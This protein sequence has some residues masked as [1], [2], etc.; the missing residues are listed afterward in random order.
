[1]RKKL[2]APDIDLRQIIMSILRKKHTL[3]LI[4]ALTIISGL[5]YHSTNKPK[6]FSTTEIV[7]ISGVE[8]NKYI[9]YNSTADLFN[10]SNIG[11]DLKQSSLINLKLEKLDKL[12]FQ[13]LFI[14]KLA[15][16]KFLIEQLKKAELI[17]KN[18]Y[19]TENGYNNAIKKLADSIKII[20]PFKDGVFNIKNNWTLE[21]ITHDKDK[22]ENFL[23][24]ISKNI[25]NDVRLYL[26]DKFDRNFLGLENDKKNIIDLINIKL[27]NSRKDYK[28]KLVKQLA[29][30]E[31]QAAIARRLDIKK[32]Y[33]VDELGE[34]VINFDNDDNSYYEKGYPRIEEEIKIIKNRVNLDEFNNELY[35][36]N[37]KK[38]ELLQNNTTTRLSNAFYK[39]PLADDK[40]NNTFVASKINGQYTI[41]KNLNLSLIAVILLAITIGLILGIFYILISN[42]LYRKK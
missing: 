26:K 15:D 12:F 36:L 25:N 38:R 40:I 20:P 42:I 34:I 5:G 8:E 30:L 1:M 27:V 14:G 22:W 41:Y 9:Q 13:N 28:N 24:Q 11:A 18:K 17:K 31:E 2:D 4:V 39:T 32:T 16:K 33:L 21:F 6:F 35:V 23:V 19:K 3:I 29:F 7:P 10:R 37:S